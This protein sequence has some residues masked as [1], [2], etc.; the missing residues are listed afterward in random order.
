M[1]DTLHLKSRY[2]FIY[3]LFFTVFMSNIPSIF[4][5]PC[6]YVLFSNSLYYI[7]II[8][9][10]SLQDLYCDFIVLPTLSVCIMRHHNHFPLTSDFSAQKLVYS[11]I[12][13]LH[14]IFF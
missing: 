2:L 6:C 4:L 10:M 11:D 3:L 14:D 1:V 7:F 5:M 8:T 13:P 9:I 12:N